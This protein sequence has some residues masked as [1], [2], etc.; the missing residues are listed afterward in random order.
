M[1]R[2][3]RYVKK[4]FVFNKDCEQKKTLK[5]KLYNNINMNVKCK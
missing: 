1:Y 2:S 4:T 3:N 5:I